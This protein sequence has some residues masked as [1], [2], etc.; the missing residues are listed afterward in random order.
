MPTLSG[1]LSDIGG[2][3]EGE[4]MVNL[5]EFLTL[6]RIFP[7]YEDL[8]R[9]V[10]RNLHIPNNIES[11]GR[12][13]SAMNPITIQEYYPN[14]WQVDYNTF[15]NS[16]T[17]WYVELEKSSKAHFGFCIPFEKIILSVDTT[18]TG[19]FD[20]NFLHTPL[21]NFNTGFGYLDEM[22]TTNIKVNKWNEKIKVNVQVP[23]VIPRKYIDVIVRSLF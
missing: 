2:G 1:F 19:L 15:I 21:A 7:N 14:Q 13:P 23:S 16:A 9:G 11:Y 10:S 6:A 12:V 3:S 8:L 18:S 4:C 17:M 22:C 20:V 5:Q